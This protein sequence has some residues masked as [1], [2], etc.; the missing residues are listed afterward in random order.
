ML[1]NPFLEADEALICY[2]DLAQNGGASP[3]GAIS[4]QR[5]VLTTHRSLLIPTD[6]L[7]SN[8]HWKQK[9]E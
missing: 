3:S 1:F 6:Q 9:T 5:M 4:S 7:S 2:Y 8:T